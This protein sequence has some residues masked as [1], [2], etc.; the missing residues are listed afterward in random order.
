MSEAETLSR[1]LGVDGALV[2]P[3]D[4][5]IAPRRNNAHVVHRVTASD[6]PPT[7]AAT[8]LPGSRPLRS[9][10][11]VAAQR[12]RGPASAASR[13]T[14][15]TPA[16]ITRFGPIAVGSSHRAVYKSRTCDEPSICR[17]S[18]LARSAPLPHKLH[19][20][21][22]RSASRLIRGSGVGAILQAGRAAAVVHRG[23]PCRSRSAIGG[24]FG[25][26]SSGSALVPALPA[27]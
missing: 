15:A 10:P 6:L 24:C 20:S 4:Q 26:L 21:R 9:G 2:R 23:E 1:T 25:Q 14:G 3:R 22:P 16:P 19:Y 8:F 5:A 27:L 12:D 17:E 18:F 13:I 7:S 11:G